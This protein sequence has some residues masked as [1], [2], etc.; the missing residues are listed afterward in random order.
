MTT[1]KQTTPKRHP[2]LD[3]IVSLSA[4]MTRQAGERLG[5][6]LIAGDVVGLIGELGS[7]KTTFVQ[8][9]AKG[10]GIAPELVRSPTFV[11]VR[12]YA[13]HPPMIH[14]DGYRLEDAQSVRWLDVEWVFSSRK[15]TV[16]E[17]ADRVAACLP[18]D[19]LELRFA[20]HTAHQ[21]TLRAIGHGPR[22]QQLGEQLVKLASGF[23]PQA[24]GS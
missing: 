20:H 12:E 7:G 17:W 21:R 8:G 14:V 2:V 9:V 10:L 4:D 22:S 19:Y 13:G 23:K 15:V 24:T 16:I 6:C 11:L 18:E 3:E 1:R 5:R